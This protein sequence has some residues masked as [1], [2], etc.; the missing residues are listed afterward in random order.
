MYN[1]VEYINAYSKPSGS[2]WQQ[3]RDE[4]VLDNNNNIIDFPVNNNNSNLFK[5]KQQATWQTGNG[6]AKDV[7]MKVPLK[8]LSNFQRTLEMPIYN[9]EISL[10]LKWSNDCFLVADTAANQKPE[11]KITDIKLYVPVVTLSTQD[12]VKLLKQ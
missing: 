9:C 5:F 8:Y 4:S 12:N 2:L 6:G 11:F 10:H 1:L 3:Y 7:E